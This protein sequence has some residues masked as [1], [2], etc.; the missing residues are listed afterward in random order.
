MALEGAV[1]IAG[2]LLCY[3]VVLRTSRRAGLAVCL[4]FTGTFVASAV[5]AERFLNGELARLSVVLLIPWA[6]NAVTLTV[7]YIS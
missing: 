1:H 6:C 2:A 5:A 3:P 4:V 7:V